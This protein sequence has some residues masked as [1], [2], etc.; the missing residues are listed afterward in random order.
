MGCRHPLRLLP[1]KCCRLLNR[2][3]LDSCA[4]LDHL[5]CRLLLARLLDGSL[6]DYFIGSSRLLL[7]QGNQFW[8]GLPSEKVQPLTMVPTIQALKL[9]TLGVICRRYHLMMDVRC[10]A[11]HL[12]HG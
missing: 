7:M 11:Y 10:V 6:P 1:R 3:G 8:R 2:D 5:G 4:G 12:I 9:L